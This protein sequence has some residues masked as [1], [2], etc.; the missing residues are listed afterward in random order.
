MRTFRSAL[1][2]STAILLAFTARAQEGEGLGHAVPIDSATARVVLAQATRQ[3]PRFAQALPDVHQHDLLL[4]RFV[5]VTASG[6]LGS[7]AAA[8][9]NGAVRLDRRFLEQP[10]PGF[11]DS[12]LGVV[13]YHEVGHLHYFT[14]VPPGRRNAAV[15]EQAA[16]EYSLLKTR[17]LA[18]AGDCAPCKPACAL[19]S[20]AAGLLTSPTRTW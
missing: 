15:S 16:F 2:L 18:D 4:R 11:D 13:L 3:Y 14:Q 1:F 17:L 19:C 10:Q 8:V 9:G 12:R 5:V 20:N 7:P 6:P